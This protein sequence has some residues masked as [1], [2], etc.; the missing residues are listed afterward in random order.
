M[1]LRN[2]N[3]MDSLAPARSA[4]RAFG[5]AKFLSPFPKQLKSSPQPKVATQELPW[6]HVRILHTSERN[7]RKP[8]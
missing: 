4:R 8:A 6:V 3:G 1:R 5:F 7:L 2:P